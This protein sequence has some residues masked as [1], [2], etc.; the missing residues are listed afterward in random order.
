[1]ACLLGLQIAAL[2]LFRGR[3][4]FR[5]SQPCGQDLQRARIDGG[6]R[7]RRHCRRRKRRA[8]VM[9]ASWVRRHEYIATPHIVAGPFD[10]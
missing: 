1:M 6:S 2:T 3:R 5:H 4:R 9:T 7:R 10:A 8:C